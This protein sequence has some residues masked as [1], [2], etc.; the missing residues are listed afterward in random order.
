MYLFVQRWVIIFLCLFN[1]MVEVVLQGKLIK[2]Y[3]FHE[4]H[5]LLDSVII[6]DKY[7]F[8]LELTKFLL[9]LL[10]HIHVCIQLLNFLNFVTNVHD[11]VWT[12]A[13]LQ[14]GFVLGMVEEPTGTEIFIIVL[15]SLNHFSKQVF[16][17]FG[18]ITLAYSGNN[19]SALQ[20]KWLDLALTLISELTLCLRY[21]W[22]KK[23]WGFGR[24]RF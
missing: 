2:V 8:L 7:V 20:T 14:L 23:G 15:E 24:N 17:W 19:L 22:G 9:N 6:I 13:A 5:H 16:I 1:I 3:V 4:V 12:I 11:F 21:W 18:D 10:L